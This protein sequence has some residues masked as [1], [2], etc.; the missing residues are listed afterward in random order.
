MR[1]PAA[2]GI[3]V[4]PVGP[5]AEHGSP[6]GAGAASAGPGAS[7]AGTVFGMGTTRM[8]AP[9]WSP[10]TLGEINAVLADDTSG[11]ADTEPVASLA[12]P[13]GPAAAVEWRSPRPLSSTAHVRMADGARLVVKRVPVALRDA[14]ALAEEHA[15]MDHLR[16]RGIPVPRVWSRVRGEFAYEF[17]T[18]GA[19]RDLYQ[20]EF[21]WSPYRSVG[22]ASAAGALL[23]RMHCAAVGF[24]ALERPVRPLQAAMCTDLVA[25]VERHAAARPALGAFLHERDWRAELD[26]VVVP[27]RLDPSGLEQLWTHNDWHGTNL[28]WREGDGREAIGAVFDFGL[29]NRTTAVFDLATAI[30]RFAVDWIALRDT[31][32]ARIHADQLAAFLRGYCDIRPLTSRERAALPEIF[33]LAQVHYQ[34]SEID[35]FLSVLPRPNIENAEIAYRSYFLGHLRWMKSADGRALCDLLRHIPA[36]PGN[37]EISVTDDGC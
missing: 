22:Q 17:Q 3:E 19:G 37:P 7:E 1:G 5:A 24:D 20:G 26:A 14:E 15:F 2:G 12:P 36:R 16:A 21:S 35:Y 6:S 27:P 33:P 9:D 18:P 32:A 13:A 10:L 34:L 23:A 30:E 31:G 25:G 29:A 28:L 4:Q 11:N 8:V